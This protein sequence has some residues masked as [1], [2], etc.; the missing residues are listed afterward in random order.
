MWCDFSKILEVDEISNLSEE[1]DNYVTTFK[2]ENK[3]LSN[4]DPRVIRSFDIIKILEDHNKNLRLSNM[5]PLDGGA[6]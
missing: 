6:K 4:K 3:K 5:I 2:T 1:L